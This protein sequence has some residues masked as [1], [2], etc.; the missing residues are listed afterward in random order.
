MATMTITTSPLIAIIRKWNCTNIV[1]VS[2]AGPLRVLIA[3]YLGMDLANYHRL[4]VS[5]GGITALG[6]EGEKGVPRVLALN[7][8]PDLA[9]L[10]G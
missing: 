10:T 6:F 3:H 7:S 4:R 8:V 5:M 1:I 2:H 9:L